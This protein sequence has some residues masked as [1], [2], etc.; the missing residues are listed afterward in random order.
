MTNPQVV[1]LEGDEYLAVQLTENKDKYLLIS[2]N[3]SSGSGGGTG[4]SPDDQKGFHL[5]KI[6]DNDVL[7]LFKIK[8]T[9]IKGLKPDPVSAG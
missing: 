2:K 5:F 9:G 1:T 4:T 6:A 8:Y 7:E 3:E